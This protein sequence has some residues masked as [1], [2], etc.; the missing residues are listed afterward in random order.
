VEADAGR[1]ASGATAADELF[2]VDYVW[3]RHD[4][5]GLELSCATDDSAG[6]DERGTAVS[7]SRGYDPGAEFSG[8]SAAERRASAGEPTVSVSGRCGCD[9]G[10]SEAG[11]FFLLFELRG[12]EA[13]WWWLAGCGEFGE[14]GEF[15]QLERRGW[16][17]L[18]LFERSG[19]G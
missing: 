15:K 2:G 9:A 4:Y 8:G 5:E 16:M 11:G 12:D 1:P 6:A 7:V 13:G 3:R 17:E 18:E 10:E 14:F 19:C